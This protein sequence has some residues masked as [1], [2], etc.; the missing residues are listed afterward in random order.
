[1][2]FSAGRHFSAQHRI[3]A[4]PVRRRRRRRGVRSGRLVKVKALLAH[5]PDLM[6]HP[7]KFPDYLRPCFL[8][9][10]SRRNLAPLG[11]SLVP[12][13]GLKVELA[14]RPR[15][16]RRRGSGGANLGNLQPLSRAAPVMLEDA[17][18]LRC[19][20][21]N[22]RSVA[23]KTFILRDHFSAHSLDLMFVT[24]TWIKAGE[25]SAFLNLFPLLHVHKCTQNYGC[26][27]GGVA[28]ILKSNICF[29]PL[30]DMRFSSFE[31]SYFTL[32]QME[33]VLCAVV[34]RPPKYN[35][36]FLT[37]F[38]DFMAIVLTDFD[39]DF[40]NSVPPVRFRRSL[41]PDTADQ[42]SLSLYHIYE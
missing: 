36:D 42:F 10:A 9:L 13:G 40:V 14:V 7:E 2:H 16:V 25:S 4:L 5:S 8:R 29:K 18:S 24:E 27:G 17:S 38:S 22:A 26:R 19:G 35:K 6:N 11:A 31:L 21:I 20:L 30:A 41:K 32:R 3:P 33:P 1:M 37:E 23:N 39:K 12:L 28:T 15:R 34:Y